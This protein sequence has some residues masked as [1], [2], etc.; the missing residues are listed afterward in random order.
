[1]NLL[2]YK[3]K[4][5]I[6]G[7]YIFDPIR[8]KNIVITP[9]ELVRQLLLIYLIEEKN[10]PVNKISIEKQILVNGLPKRFD[11]LVYSTDFQPIMLVECKAPAIEITNET[12]YQAARYNRTLQ[13]QH[14]VLTNGISTVPFKIN[15]EN[16]ELE[17]LDEILNYE[18]L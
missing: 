16:E 8:K 17:Y 18:D 2:A 14:C 7:K 3:S 4:L 12:M 10:F 11:I 13:V 6:R 5:D 15:Y 1:M 9:E